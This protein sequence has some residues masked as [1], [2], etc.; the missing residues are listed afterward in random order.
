MNETMNDIPPLDEMV[1][2]AHHVRPHWR[3][4]FGSIFSLGHDTLTERAHL[5]ERAFVEEGITAMLP[6]EQPVNWRCDP[7]PLILSAEEFAGL[8]VGLAQR[9]RLIEAILSDIYG[10]GTLVD[11]GAIPPDLV[12]GNP[13]FLRP[14]RIAGTDR[15]PPRHLH[16]Y[17]ADLMRGP[18]G[19]WRVMA[20]RADQARGLA[21]ALENRRNLAR[22]VPEIFQNQ[23]IEPLRPFMEAAG[24]A[25]R[26]LA[27]G[28]EGGAALLSGGHADPLWFEHVLLARELSIGLVE[29]GDLTI[30]GGLVYL[31]TLRGLERISVLFRRQLG[32]RMDPLELH[33]S[34]PPGLLDAMR[35]GSVHVVNHPG[36]A[37]AESPALAAFLPGLARQMLGEDLIT[38]SQATLYLGDGANLRTVLRDLQGWVIRNA[39]DGGSVPVVP[40]HLSPEKRAELAAQVAARPAHYAALM[41]PTPSVAPCA[42]PTGLEPRPVVLRMFLAHDGTTWR[43]MPGGLARALTDEDAIA[44]RLPRDAVSK[45]V[46]V[47]PDEFAAS[48]FVP[49]LD[50]RPMEIRRTAGD[51]PSRVADNFYWLGRYLERMEEAARLRRALIPRVSRPSASPHER[52]DIDLLSAC[53][54]KAG[55]LRPEDTF[56]HGTASRNAAVLGA[57]RAEGPMRRLLGRVASMSEQ[58]RDRL[59]GEV[60]TILTRSLHSLGEAMNRLPTD[61]DP[62]AVERASALTTDI[63]Q[64]SAAIAGLA[65]ENMV[66]GGGRLFFDFGRRVE[67]AHAILEQLAVLLE[68]PPGPVQQGHVEAGL[69]LALELRDSVITY[70]ARY[71]AVLQAA[72]ALDLMLADEGNPRGLAFQLLAMRDLLRQITEEGDSLLGSV[73]R[74]LRDAREIVADVLAAPNQMQAAA[75]LTE[76]LSTLELA[77]ESIADR[78]SRRYFT[79]L[80]IARSL[81]VDAEPASLP[82]AA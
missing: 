57:F 6:G 66:R 20:D 42:T 76:T 81:S 17:A 13:A 49:A 2:G 19:I 60:H 75:R 47:L 44:G 62:R 36:S 3:G 7:I 21:Y 67:R 15:A 1:D 59:T 68:Q 31:K 41:A 11:S 16:V 45:D 35:S 52:A 58:L 64:F 73:D 39:N 74:A 82:G 26:A 80:P 77:I 72:P 38:P 23:Q 18:D 48:R 71:L 61:G 24:E 53:L 69:Q 10:P 79:L 30:R 78:V 56:E 65:A 33:G 54:H 40:E 22:I 32:A 14:C 12:Y 28:G 70:R 50:T 4:V 8:E 34:G 51:L 27:P 55:M 9:A 29:P 43:T 25:L 63:L 46:W 5:L 37:L